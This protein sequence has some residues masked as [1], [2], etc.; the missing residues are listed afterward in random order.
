M[1]K[2]IGINQAR[3]RAE[4]IRFET[5][6]LAKLIAERKESIEI[7]ARALRN[8]CPHQWGETKVGLA[9]SFRVC[10]VCGKFG[11]IK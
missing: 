1:S 6:R 10:E 11:E 3:M 7:N 9:Y 2:P 5:A 8:V 4:N